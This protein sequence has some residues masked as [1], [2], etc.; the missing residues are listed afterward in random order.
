MKKKLIWQIIPVM[1]LVLIPAFLICGY[2]AFD[3]VLE[4]CLKEQKA[5]LYRTTHYL[6]SEIK[7]NPNYEW[8]LQYWSEHASQLCE[9]MEYDSPQALSRARQEFAKNNLGIIDSAV[10]ANALA[11]LDDS[12]QE[13]YARICL[14]DV[15]LE[16][17]H[18][19]ES[20]DCKFIYF[21][22]LN[23]EADMLFLISGLRQGEKRGDDMM[24]IFRIGKHAEPGFEYHP[25]MKEIYDT[26]KA[27]DTF[28]KKYKNGRTGSDYNYYVPIITQ[29]QSV[30]II[31][32]SKAAGTVQKDIINGAKII[33]MVFGCILILGTVLMVIAFHSVLLKPLAKVQGQIR[34]FT[35]DKDADNLC[36]VLAEIESKNEIGILSKDVSGLATELTDYVDKIANLSAKNQRIETELNLAR[37]IQKAA[38]PSEIPVFEK[39]NNFEIF[40]ASKPAKEVG[41]DFFDYFKLDDDHLAILI[42]DVAGKGIPAAMFMMFSH[43][44]IKN[45]ARTI[46]NPAEIFEN[47]NEILMERN[48]TEMFVTAWFG[49][50]DLNTCELV[51]VNAGHENPAMCRNDKSYTLIK[52]RHSLVLA[53][54]ENTVYKTETMKLEKGDSLFLYTDGVPEATNSENELYGVDRMLEALN[55]VKTLSCEEIIEGV[56]NDIQDFV[57]EASQFDDCT[58]ICLRINE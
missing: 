9:A 8:V 50:L 31:C 33:V 37:G 41:G 44:C 30:Y 39:H 28:E 55:R 10:D 15:T 4:I 17:N 40:G 42:A 24:D 46:M 52:N 5:D 51:S 36:A 56:R 26:R 21:A 23:S 12:S 45:M 29:D 34:K 47:V 14:M 6:E 54:M 49:I 32:G 22:K 27:V 3:E 58:M 2:L 13:L 38:L 25:V 7:S 1:L 35:Q 48:E 16:F 43:I 20:N 11:L 57:D 53:G 18:I 19:K